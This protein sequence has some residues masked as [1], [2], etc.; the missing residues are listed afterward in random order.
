MEIQAR[1]RPH[2]PRQRGRF[3]PALLFAILAWGPGPAQAVPATL[4]QSDLALAIYAS[5]DGTTWRA[6]GASALAGFFGA[7]RCLCPDTLLVQVALTSSGQ[8]NLGASTLAANFLLGDNCLTTPAACVSVGQVSFSASQTAASPTFSS[9]LVFQTVA[10]SATVACAS[11]TA[12]STKLWAVLAQDGV[13]LSFPLS[14]DLPVLSTTVGAPTAVTAQPANEGILVAWTPPADTSLVAGYQVLCLPRPAV[15]LT[16]GYESC[17][18]GS[19]TGAA[20]L[21]PADATEICSAVVSATTTSTRLTGLTNGTLYSVAVVAID[22]SGGVSAPSPKAQATPETT[23]GFYGT[24]KQD[25]GA[26]TGCSLAPS[27]PA[28]RVALFWMALAVVAVLLP[29]RRR[30]RGSR[31]RSARGACILALLLAGGGTAQAQ[32]PRYHENDD[33][34]AAP[35]APRMFSPPDWGFELGVSLYRPAVDGEFG[36]GVHPFAD[37]FSNSRH[38]LSEAELDRY[39][40]HRFGTWG[41][42]LRAGYYKVTAAAFLADGVTRS[43]D[44]TGLRLIPCSLSLLYRA[45]GLPGLRVVPLI[46][47]VKAGLDGVLWTATNT[48]DSGSQTGFSLGWH[49]AAGTMLGLNFLAGGV[50]HPGAIAD[51]C[52]LFFEWD[53]AAIDGLGFGHTLHVGDSTWFA[54]IM[55]DL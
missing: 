2:A 41:V 23:M 30:R 11:L 10:G 54:G 34:A 3:L 31:R 5:P 17:G 14:L 19:A 7:H 51:P 6:L 21:T 55:F 47:Y 40:G 26:A 45:D 39:L 29:S 4:G 35:A 48:G 25:G 27:P 1:F 28:R 32:V 42:G 20:S 9:S 24:Y 52:A 53:Y 18:L 49:V 8:T 13:A 43:G 15:A 33:W 46:P 44:E 38:L 12:G 37:T 50:V 16:A 22:P 36:N